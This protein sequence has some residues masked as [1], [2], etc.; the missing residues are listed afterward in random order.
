[1][2]YP[3]PHTKQLLHK[4]EILIGELIVPTQFLRF[5]VD[6]TTKTVTKSILILHG[7][8]ISML[9]IKIKML[10]EQE[11]A[12]IVR[13]TIENTETCLDLFYTI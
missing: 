2:K 3:I 9:D 13:A 7:R 5:V 8:K 1:M 11:D 6:K 4:I 10:R 12:G